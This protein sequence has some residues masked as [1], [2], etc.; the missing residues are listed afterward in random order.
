[1]VLFGL[2][3]A[4]L[5]RAGAALY[6]DAL[7]LRIVDLEGLDVRRRLVVAMRSR[8]ALS[9][10]ARAFVTMIEARGATTPQRSA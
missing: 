6:A 10:A 2:G 7:K 8:A 9:P 1:M 3:L 5:P 4:I